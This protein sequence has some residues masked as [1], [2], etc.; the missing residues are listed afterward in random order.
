MMIDKFSIFNEAKVNPVTQLLTDVTAAFAY[1]VDENP[2]VKIVRNTSQ[3][4][5]YIPSLMSSTKIFGNAPLV[6]FGEAL[7]W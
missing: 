6:A 2:N 3:V 7:K 1:I 5:V 4:S